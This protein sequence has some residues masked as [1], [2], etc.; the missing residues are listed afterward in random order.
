MNKTV[1]AR[2]IERKPD[3]QDTN[4]ERVRETEPKTEREK[5]KRRDV[6]REGKIQREEEGVK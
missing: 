6:Q 1:R 3:W 5:E 2:E 4:T